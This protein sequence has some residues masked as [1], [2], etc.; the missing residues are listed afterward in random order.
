MNDITI[1]WENG[2]LYAEANLPARHRLKSRLIKLHEQRPD[3]FQRFVLNNDGTLYAKFPHNWVRLSPPKKVK[4]S[5]EARQK[6][7]VSIRKAREVQEARRL[8][9]VST[10]Q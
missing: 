7:S 5:E 9:N 3:D 1:G 2:E 4:L 6:R 8:A 10:L